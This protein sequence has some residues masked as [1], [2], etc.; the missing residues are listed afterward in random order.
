M[1]TF[2]NILKYSN[3]KVLKCSKLVFT[4]SN[5]YKNK[6]SILVSIYFLGFLIGLI[7]FYVKQIFYIKKEVIKLLL[8]EKQKTKGKEVKKDIN[9]QSP[10]IYNKNSAL[11]NKSISNKNFDKKKIINESVK[12]NKKQLSIELNNLEKNQKLNGTTNQLLNNKKLNYK[13]D[14]KKNLDD[15]ELN[16]LEYTEAIKLD[17]RTFFNIYIY[18]L[19]REQIILFT[20]FYF[21]DFNIFSLK[22]SKFFLAICTDM[23]FNVFFFSDESMHNIYISGGEHDFIGQLAQIIY[24][25]IV[26]QILQIFINYLAMT[27]ITYYTIKELIQEKNTNENKIKS[28]MT[29]LKFKILIFFIF[30]SGLFLFFWYFVT[31]FCSVYENTQMIFITDSIS[32]FAIGL[33]YPFFLYLIPTVLRILSLKYK[34]KKFLYSLSDKIPFF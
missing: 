6:G 7:I 32:S 15:Y 18:F 2:Y 19:K 34:N 4:T 30:S 22:L 12:D 24:S 17:N 28:I 26:S 21:N 1:K 9:L 3:Y 33:I 25:T 13:K 27:D 5:L 29:C 14:K 11:K 16:N 23:A 8:K 10:I 20:F 31:A